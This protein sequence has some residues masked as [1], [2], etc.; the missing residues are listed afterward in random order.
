MAVQ[1]TTSIPHTSDG[2]SHTSTH[3]TK[4]GM[5]QAQ[6]A[7]TP[8]VRPG[9]PS[10]MA[11]GRYAL[12]V[13]TARIYGPYVRPVHTGVCLTPVYTARIYGPYKIAILYG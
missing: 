1:N 11:K 6:W 5:H 10:K 8:L 3:C 7:Y 2:R 12:P 4:K 13:N 9:L